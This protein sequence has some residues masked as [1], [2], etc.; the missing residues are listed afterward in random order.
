MDGV[1]L[2]FVIVYARAVH[3]SKEETD[4]NRRGERSTC[5]R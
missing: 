1:C 2:A 5:E 4:Q 3:E